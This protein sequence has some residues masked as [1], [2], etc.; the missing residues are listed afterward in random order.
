MQTDCA[1]VTALSET[2]LP[3]I[4]LVNMRTGNAHPPDATSSVRTTDGGLRKQQEADK[5]PTIIT[6]LMNWPLHCM[7]TIWWLICLTVHGLH[8]R[9]H[10][11]VDSANL[12]SWQLLALIM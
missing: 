7:L 9:P 3:R 8:D 11:I 5:W 6:M 12:E 4:V 2:C 1:E 10:T